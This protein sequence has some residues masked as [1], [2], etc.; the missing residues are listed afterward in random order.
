MVRRPFVYFIEPKPPFRLDLTAWALRRRP[1]NLIDRWS[2]GTYRRVIGLDAGTVEVAV[3]QSALAPQPRLRVEVAGQPCTP[4]LK[5]SISSTLDRLLGLQ[6]DLSGFHLLASRRK[7][8]GAI[9]DRFSGFRSPRFAS[10][11]EAIVNGIACQQV[12]LTLGIQLLGRLASD[13]GTAFLRDGH[14]PSHAFPRPAEL[15]GLCSEDFRRLG[16][17]HAKGRAIIELSRAIED[18][19]FNP[20]QL[21]E[22]PDQ[23][24]MTCLTGLRGVGRWTAQYVLLR[25]LGRTHVFPGDDVGARNHL[26]RWLQ[27]QQPLSYDTVQQV[28]AP[29]RPY[30]GLIYF[31]L[32]LDQLAAG[33]LIN[34][35][36]AELAPFPQH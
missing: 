6:V 9:A 5:A 7:K 1:D 30:S 10:V 12:T 28:L 3:T 32:L 29:W 25:G 31:H 26:Q 19:S 27:I 11:Y 35:A 17:T 16:F 4:R 8:L 18:G 21:S 20:E 14:P 2:D 24:A 36:T 33:R 34:P 23:E 13:Y 15:A 22:M